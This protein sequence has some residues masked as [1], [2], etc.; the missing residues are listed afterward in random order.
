MS[1]VLENSRTF[2]AKAHKNIRV[3][4]RV[5]WGLWLALSAHNPITACLERLKQH[6]RA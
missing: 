2:W 1:Y 6:K 5:I 4:R 3:K